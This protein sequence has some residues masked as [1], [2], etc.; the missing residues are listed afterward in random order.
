MQRCDLDAVYAIE[1]DSFI[2]PWS[3]KSLSDDLKNKIAYYGVAEH[4]EEILAYAGMWVLFDEAHITNVAVRKLSRGCGLGRSIMQH[5]ISVAK[6][7][8]ACKMT[9]EVRENNAVAQNLYK[10]L[11]FSLCGIRKGYYSDTGEAAYIM[12]AD[13]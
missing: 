12:W 2:T 5:M 9:L 10:S 3:K 1:C 8:G 13:I 11:G 4:E 6:Q 7:K